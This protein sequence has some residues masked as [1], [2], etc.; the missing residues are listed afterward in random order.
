VWESGYLRSL[1][2][3]HDRA[4][5]YICWGCL[6]WLPSIYSSSTM[7][8]VP[9][10]IVLGTPL[11]ATIFS[12]GFVFIMLN[13]AADH[14]RHRVRQ[15]WFDKKPITVWGKKPTIIETHYKSE[16]GDIK[17]TILLASG[18][19]GLS[20]HFH[21]L[22]EILGSICWVLPCGFTHVQPWFYI[23]YLSILLLERGTRD[24]VRCASKYG[25]DWKKYCKLV[26][27]RFIP[28]IF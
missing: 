13:W 7:F 28:G 6:V 20:R 2:I 12:F 10:H 17:E 23:V 22:P 9:R 11:A 18:F 27:Y 26:P 4:G 16:Q 25:E 5:Y 15:L 1:D 8:L 14:Q 21:Y 24:D 19:W 3:M